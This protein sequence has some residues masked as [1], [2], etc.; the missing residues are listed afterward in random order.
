[1]GG[2]ITVW[3]LLLCLFILY[4][5][6]EQIIGNHDIKKTTLTSEKFEIVKGKM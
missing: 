5:I 3:V 4:F 6:I 2:E 1:M